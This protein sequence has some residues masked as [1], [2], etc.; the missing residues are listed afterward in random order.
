MYDS[1]VV[2]VVLLGGF[3]Q[4]MMGEDREV[5]GLEEIVAQRHSK[6]VNKNV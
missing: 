6:G 5:L 4:T 1:S 3:N 2:L